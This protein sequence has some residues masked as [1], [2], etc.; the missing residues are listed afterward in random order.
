M[1]EAHFDSIDEINNKTFNSTTESES[2]SIKLDPINVYNDTTDYFFGDDPSDLSTEE[3][4][5]Q[6]GEFGQVN[7][8]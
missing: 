6:T 5:W 2:Y 1:S 3:F 7:H 8:F 4:E